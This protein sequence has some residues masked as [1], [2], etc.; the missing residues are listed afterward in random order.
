EQPRAGVYHP[1]VPSGRIEDWRALADPDRPTVGVTFYRAYWSSGDTDFINTLVEAG[2]A[3]GLNGLPGYA[4]SPKDGP[5][6][7]ATPGAFRFFVED[8]APAVDA[9]VNT[10][11]FAMGSSSM[12]GRHEGEWAVEVLDR[13]GIPQLQAMNASL[14]V[15][16]WRESEGGLPPLDV[17]M[18]VAIP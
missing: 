3:R 1:R 18:N 2:E 10:M 12:E 17:A 5:A 7:D 16:R 9:V 14:S 8:G 13:L 15:E 4:Y 6:A 11:A